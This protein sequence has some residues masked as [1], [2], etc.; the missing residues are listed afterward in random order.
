[1]RTEEVEFV[2]MLLLLDCWTTVRMSLLVIMLVKI[3][4]NKSIKITILLVNLLAKIDIV[5]KNGKGGK[6]VDFR[7]SLTILTF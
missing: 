1:M 2:A 5:S 4:H 6:N 7:C 3:L